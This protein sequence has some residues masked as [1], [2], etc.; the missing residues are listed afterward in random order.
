MRGQGYENNDSLGSCKVDY[1]DEHR[2]HFP[3]YFTIYALLNGNSYDRKSDAVLV[4]GDSS[5]DPLF[6]SDILN[7]VEKNIS[8]KSNLDNVISNTICLHNVFVS[9]GKLGQCVT[10]VI[11]EFKRNH[12]SD[13]HISN[14]VNPHQEVA[15]TGSSSQR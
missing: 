9:C 6:S 3:C 4:G 13:D 8:E 12:S 1:R 11:S 2:F 15:P 7:K 10:Q 5:N 14:V